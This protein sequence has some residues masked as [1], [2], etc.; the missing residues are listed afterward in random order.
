MLELYTGDSTVVLFADTEDKLLA[1]AEELASVNAAK[2]GR[3]SIGR[4]QDLPP[5]L[6]GAVEGTRG[7][8]DR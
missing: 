8:S 3:P 5:P 1:L 6:P 2:L 4:G 7:C